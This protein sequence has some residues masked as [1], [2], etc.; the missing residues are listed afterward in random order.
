MTDDERAE[1]YRLVEGSAEIQAEIHSFIEEAQRR[2]ERLRNSSRFTDV[3]KRL[4]EL[5]KD[6]HEELIDIATNVMIN[7]GHDE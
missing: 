7:R 4:S 2:A 1:A 6:H 5:D 3:M